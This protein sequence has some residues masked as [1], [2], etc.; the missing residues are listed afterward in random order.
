MSMRFLAVAA[1]LSAAG[2]AQAEL[3]ETARLAG[4]HRFNM[5]TGAVTTVAAPGAS[6]ADRGAPATVLYNNLTA[7]AA[8]TSAFSQAGI[9]TTFGDRVT[10]TGTGGALQDFAFTL[11]NSTTS[12]TTAITTGTMNINFARAA[13]NSPLGGFSVP[14][15]PFLGAGGLAPGFFTV[16]SLTGISLVTNINF[17]T[18]DVLITQTLSGANGGR[19][20]VAFF[21]PVVAGSSIPQMFLSG[22]TANLAAGYYNI[23]TSP[24]F[25]QA[26]PG[27]FVFIPSPGAAALL[28][29]GGLVA[30]RRRR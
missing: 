5:A 8:V 14:L 29:M 18:N 11:F 19:N 26:N 17:D 6:V 9:T 4:M 24:N 20:G 15:A 21:N 28:G 25:L 3:V 7:P 12:N 30:M 27:Y 10:L 1:V 23:G 2:M 22:G 16:I 13:D